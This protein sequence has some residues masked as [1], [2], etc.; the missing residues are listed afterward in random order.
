MEESAEK[1]L[2]VLD[3]LYKQVCLYMVSSTA[4]KMK[5]REG[6]GE[7]RER[8]RE[9]KRERGE[10]VQNKGSPWSSVPHC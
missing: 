8:E 9:R 7:E 1:L 2:K 6:E 5:E 10:K 3:T 4:E